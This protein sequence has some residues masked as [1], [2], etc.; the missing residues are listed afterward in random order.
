VASHADPNPKVRGRGLA[1]LRRAGVRV[2]VG[3]MAAES[4]ALNEAYLT[5]IERKRPLVIVKAAMTLDGRIA[6]ARG[7]SRWISGAASRR[8]AHRWRADC[9]AV[10]V[11]AGTVRA[12]DPRLTARGVAGRQPIRVVVDGKL[13]VTPRSRLLSGRGGGPVIIYTSQ[14]APAS[15]RAALERAGATV[16]AV[17]AARE[18]LNLRAVLRDL[19]RRRVTRLLIEGGGDLIAS[20]LREGL[21]DHLA[22]FVAP[23]LLGGRHGVPV[24]GG[25]DAAS[26]RQAI[27]LEAITCRRVGKDMLIQARIGEA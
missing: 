20:V 17:P 13:A 16:R 22:L 11:G 14:A 8:L 24:V 18:G 1:A 23:M 10:M 25:R 27:R 19:A 5:W 2:D 12:D 21:V 6:T 4:R 7:A 3:L 9:D 15:R 26:L